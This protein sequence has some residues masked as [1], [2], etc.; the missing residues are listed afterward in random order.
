MQAINQAC[1]EQMGLINM[2]LGPEHQLCAQS[3]VLGLDNALNLLTCD[4]A[5]SGP[6]PCGEQ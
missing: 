5:G 4:N 2:S 1:C 6:A 3:Y